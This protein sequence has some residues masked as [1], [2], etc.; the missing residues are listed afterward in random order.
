M[1]I[2][3]TISHV[4]RALSSTKIVL[5]PIP[6]YSQY[7][8]LANIRTFHASSFTMARATESKGSS[9]N[10]AEQAHDPMTIEEI[11]RSNPQ[12]STKLSTAKQ[13]NACTF[14]KFNA[15]RNARPKLTTQSQS[16]CLQK[17]QNPPRNLQ[18]HQRS[19]QKE[20]STHVMAL[21]YTSSI[22]RQ[23]LRV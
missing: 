1:Y 9:S 18:K 8:L 7:L 4:N 3:Y 21:A 19:P 16:S 22:L 23:T 6:R 14:K 2:A 20:V 12:A 11:E 13:T 15:I 5:E 10:F 17:S